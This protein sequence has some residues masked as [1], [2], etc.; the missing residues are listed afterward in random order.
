MGDIQF[1]ETILNQIQD[2]LNGNITKEEYYNQSEEF[3]TKYASTYKNLA[4]HEY[5]LSTVP[6]AC[7]FYIDEPGL[8][9][10]IK[11]EKFREALQEAYVILQKL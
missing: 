6:D 3:Y 8:P 5:F 7:L 11:E 1:R 4:F 10:E 9:P 2:Y